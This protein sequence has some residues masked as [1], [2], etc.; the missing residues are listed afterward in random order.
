M[1]R[2]SDKSKSARAANDDENVSEV[3]A[4]GFVGVIRDTLQGYVGRVI[5]PFIFGT[6]L[7]AGS[8]MWASLTGNENLQKEMEQK[9]MGIMNAPDSSDKQ[10]MEAIGM[11]MG[12]TWDGALRSDSL[13]EKIQELEAKLESYQ[14]LE[15]R[16]LDIQKGIVD[17]QHKVNQL[18]S[19]VEQEREYLKLL[20]EKANIG[21]AT[22]QEL[23][24]QLDEV[25][26]RVATQQKELSKA[27]SLIAPKDS[28]EAQD[29]SDE[30]FSEL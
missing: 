8:A 13:A 21:R 20:G 29:K 15:S 17:S 16:L 24:T 19:V 10:V 6:V 9:L 27:W 28:P 7:I 3:L 12:M 1:A 30:A 25:E 26:S 2:G 5:L 22:L 14:Q 11:A 4:K 18:T 23:T